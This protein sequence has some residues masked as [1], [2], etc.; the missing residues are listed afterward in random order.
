MEEI[1]PGLLRELAGRRGMLAQVVRGGT[2]APGDAIHLV[3]D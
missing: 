3:E 2:I 1:R